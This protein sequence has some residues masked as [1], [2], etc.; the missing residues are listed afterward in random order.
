[1]V[2]RLKVMAG[3]NIAETR[4]PQDGRISLTISGR[5][6]DYRSAVQ[7]TIHG[8][9][10][11]LRILDRKRGIVPLDGL[12]LSEEQLHIMQLMLSRPEGIMLVTGPTGSGKTTTLYSILGHLNN[13]GVNI[14]T[15]EDPV[16]Y[17]MPMIRQT[18]IAESVKMDFAEGIRSMMRQDP[19]IIL[20]GEVRDHET[21]EMAF[22]AAMTGHQVFSTLHTNSAIR[23]IPRLVDLGIKPEVLAG[24]VIGIVAQ[25][26]LRTLCVAC[27]APH[28]PSPIELQLLGYQPG[29]A[30]TLYRPVGCRQCEHLGYKGRMSILELLKFDAELD[31]LVTQRAS[32]KVLLEHVVRNGFV[33]MAQDGLRRVRQ[34]VTTVEEVGRVVDLTE[35]IY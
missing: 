1:M 2:V 13:E 31:E 10:F 19:D 34:G 14:M 7:P 33:S 22:R 29:Q 21:A 15:L 25:R 35:L 23:S 32:L 26:L 30:H 3:M 5:Q 4:A 28:D 24:N 17:P 11:V 6:V 18:S 9:N 27:K 8:E 12:G 16:E 20:V